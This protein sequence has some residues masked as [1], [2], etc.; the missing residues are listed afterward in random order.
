MVAHC[1]RR[2]RTRRCGWLPVR[3][4]LAPGPVGVRAA[5]TE[6]QAA[7]EGQNSTGA[8]PIRVVPGSE[9]GGCERHVGA[10]WK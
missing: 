8:A 1:K 3:T 7:E 10:M 9:R 2:S 6:A 4:A 5:A